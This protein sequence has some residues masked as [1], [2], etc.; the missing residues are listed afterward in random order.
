[1]KKS[2]IDQRIDDL[3]KYIEQKYSYAQES[4]FDNEIEF[5]SRLFNREIGL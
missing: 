4:Q 1:M 3:L 2:M 5:F